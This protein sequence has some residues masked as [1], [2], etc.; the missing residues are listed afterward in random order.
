MQ[1]N[2]TFTS[3]LVDPE[4]DLFTCDVA[5]NFF[6]IQQLDPITDRTLMIDSDNTVTADD[7]H[8][9]SNLAGA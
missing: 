2:F 1:Y 6:A 3:N 4:P 9:L 7:I 5:Y 8:G